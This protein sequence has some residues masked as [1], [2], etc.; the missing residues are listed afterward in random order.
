M[1]DQLVRD[2]ATATAALYDTDLYAWALAQAERL[3]ARDFAGLDLDHLI[4]AVEEIA[5]A[6]RSAV[7]NNAR[8]V[9]E[10]LLKLQHSPAVDPRNKWRASVREHRQRLEIDLSKALRRE[11]QQELPRVYRLARSAAEGSMRESGEHAAARG[12]PADCPYGLDEIAGD[13]WPEEPAQG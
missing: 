9:I 5:L 12:L 6:E 4:R 13:W 3:R 10:H 11:L 7:L 1:T 2:R 8:I